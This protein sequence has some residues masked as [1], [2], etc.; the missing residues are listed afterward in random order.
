MNLYKILVTT[1][2]NS[3]WGTSCHTLLVEFETKG[4]AD[5][6][7]GKIV[8]YSDQRVRAGSGYSQTAIRLF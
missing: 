7:I 4:E 3:S 1:I 2:V 8:E 6:A 5:T